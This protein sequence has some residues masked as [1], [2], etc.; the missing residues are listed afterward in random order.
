LRRFSPQVVFRFSPQWGKMGDNASGTVGRRAPAAGRCERIDAAVV[1]P[2]FSKD[3]AT[4]SRSRRVPV[5]GFKSL[6]LHLDVR[7]LYEALLHTRG[8][9]ATGVEG[10]RARTT[11]GTCRRTCDRC[12][13]GPSPAL[14]EPCRWGVCT[15]TRHSEA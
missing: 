12:W 14:T 1:A 4:G 10:R 13:H 6:N 9:G 8:D 5:K 15:C 11:P 7:G 2:D 3:G